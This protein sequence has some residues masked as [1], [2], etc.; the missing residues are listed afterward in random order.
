MTSDKTL[1]MYTSMCKC[2]PRCLYNYWQIKEPC[3]L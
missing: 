3:R 1:H 2:I